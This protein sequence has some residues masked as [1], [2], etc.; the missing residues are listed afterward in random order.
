MQAL[1]PPVPPG[2]KVYGMASVEVYQGQEGKP[3]IRIVIPER[4]KPD[5]EIWLT[6]NVVEMI[7]GAAR[8]ARSRY[9]AANLG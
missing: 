3:V 4:D 1:W 9:E 7:G 8:G 5:H 6:G 2:T